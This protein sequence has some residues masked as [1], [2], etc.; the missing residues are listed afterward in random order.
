MV[1]RH[2][3]GDASLEM[4]SRAEN[5][6]EQTGECPHLDGTDE[7]GNCANCGNDLPAIPWDVPED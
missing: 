4:I 7:Q 6:A 2:E 3:W 1:D 5:L